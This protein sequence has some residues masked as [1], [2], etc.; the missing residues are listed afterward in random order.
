MGL[1]DSILEEF[2]QLPQGERVAELAEGMEGMDS[3]EFSAKYATLDA[4]H[5][6]KMDR[7]IR[8]FANGA[9]GDDMF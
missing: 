8:D 3:E 4:P 1:L 2:K 7:I 6:K 5:K 9:I